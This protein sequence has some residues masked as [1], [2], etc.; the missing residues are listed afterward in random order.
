MCSENNELCILYPRK[1]H[2]FADRV[3]QWIRR[4]PTEQEILGSIP[5]MVGGD[6]QFGRV[7]KAVDSKSTGVSPR[8]FKSCS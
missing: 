3:A 2:T 1:L 4:L 6:C 5:S 7:V 8:R